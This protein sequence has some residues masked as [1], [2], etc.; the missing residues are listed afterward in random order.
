MEGRLCVSDMLKNK[1]YVK[2]AVYKIFMKSVFLVILGSVA[3]CYFFFFVK[4]DAE[5]LVFN[6]VS[7]VCLHKLR[8][9]VTLCPL[10]INMY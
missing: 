9:D 6:F 4:E 5:F 1:M 3:L 7:S 10:N 2:E 8:A